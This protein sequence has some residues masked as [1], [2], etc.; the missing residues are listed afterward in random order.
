M[1]NLHA[2]GFAFGEQEMA[3]TEGVAVGYQHTCLDV[4]SSRRGSSGQKYQSRS[5]KEE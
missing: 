2:E 5:S 1:V 4:P 3:E